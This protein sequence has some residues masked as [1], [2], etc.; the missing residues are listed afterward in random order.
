MKMGGVIVVGLLVFA[1]V[2]WAE[3]REDAGRGAVSQTHHSVPTADGLFLV[4]EGARNATLDLNQ[5]VYCM[6]PRFE[7]RRTADGA[8]DV[9]TSFYSKNRAIV[10]FYLVPVYPDT[11]DVLR[12]LRGVNSQ[13]SPSNIIPLLFSNVRVDHTLFH[14]FYAVPE[15]QESD[16]SSSN[17]QISVSLNAHDATREDVELFVADMREGGGSLQIY[18]RVR[19]ARAKLNQMDINWNEI[20]ETNA[21][22]D[23]K[24]EAGDKVVTAYQLGRLSMAITRQINVRLWDELGTDS[25]EFLDAA[26]EINDLLFANVKESFVDVT[27]LRDVLSS[28]EIDLSSDSFQPTVLTRFAA[29]VKNLGKTEWKTKYK[30]LIE[31]SMMSKDVG[32]KK[33]GGNFV[34]KMIGIGGGYERNWDKLNERERKALLEKEDYFF[35]EYDKSFHV[36]QEGKIIKRVD[37]RVYS[38]VPIEIDRKVNTRT[39]AVKIEWFD[40]T[41]V[42]LAPSDGEEGQGSFRKQGL[43]HRGY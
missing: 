3:T 1:A 10:T 25:T 26:A 21:Y 43:G 13:I 28:Y 7:I 37:V 4:Y 29:D 18:G 35:N 12:H 42:N 36:E 41:W 19:F 14:T 24:Q 20:G 17:S 16:I 8:V 30:N 40:N 5:R 34:F 33:A 22:R 23:F 32:G 31:E 9:R 27:T 38:N 6:A 2:T 15:G 11:R 39:T